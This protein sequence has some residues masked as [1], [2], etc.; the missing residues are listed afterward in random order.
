MCFLPRR[1]ACWD[2][3]RRRTAH[4]CSAFRPQWSLLLYNGWFWLGLRISGTE[5]CR[6]IQVRFIAFRS[7]PLSAFN[8]GPGCAMIR[9]VRPCG[10]RPRPKCARCSAGTPCRGPSVDQTRKT[11]SAAGC[12][13]SAR[14]PIILN[15]RP[16]IT[17]VAVTIFCDPRDHHRRRIR[18]RSE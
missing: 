5:R 10:G 15:F 12:R 1:G 6:S 14:Q 4:S 16:H 11:D 3:W 17:P 13:Q 9:T 7:P 8:V 2:R 18:P